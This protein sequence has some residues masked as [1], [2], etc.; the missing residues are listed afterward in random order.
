MQHISMIKKQRAKMIKLLE[1][2]TGQKLHDIGF[3]DDFLDITLKVQA[4]KENRQT[5]FQEN[6]KTLYIKKPY[7]KRQHRMR[8]NVYQ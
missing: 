7:H 6:L 1:E 3:G 8:E 4:T 2:N 5:G